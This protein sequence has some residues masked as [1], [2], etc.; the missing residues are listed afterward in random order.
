MQVLAGREKM[1][2]TY[3]LTIS[4]N[5]QKHVSVIFS[6]V[7]FR[8]SFFLLSGVRFFLFTFHVSLVNV[9]IGSYNHCELWYWLFWKVWSR[10]HIL[11][12][13]RPPTPDVLYRW[14]RSL[15]F[16]RLLSRGPRLHKISLFLLTVHPRSLCPESLSFTWLENCYNMSVNTNIKDVTFDEQY[17]HSM[18]MKREAEQSRK[19]FFKMKDGQWLWPK[20]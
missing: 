17:D 2:V 18:K 19:A 1:Q 15:V 9:V 14:H 10:R 7:T 6:S 12:F 8:L 20:S 16:F 11:F 3:D 5:K 13:R 4:T